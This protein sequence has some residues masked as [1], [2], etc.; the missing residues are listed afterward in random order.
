MFQ[1]TAVLTLLVVVLVGSGTS[2]CLDGNCTDQQSV[3]LLH[4]NLASI[5]PF[6]GP[7]DINNEQNNFKD[8]VDV[9][10]TTNVTESSGPK[11]GIISINFMEVITR[12][13]NGD[14]VESEEDFGSDKRPFDIFSMLFKQS[15]FLDVYGILDLSGLSLT[16]K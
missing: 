16:G 15:S 11:E 2:E 13:N 10:P 9:E 8:A 7:V 12:N 3:P 6:I 5:F 4:I 1:G 14:L